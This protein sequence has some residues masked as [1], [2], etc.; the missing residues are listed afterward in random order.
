MSLARAN[1]YKLK[2]RDSKYLQKQKKSGDAYIEELEKELSEILGVFKTHI[3]TLSY[4]SS[5]VSGQ[6]LKV[7]EEIH[8][9]F[10]ESR[11]VFDKYNID[12]FQ[13]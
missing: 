3:Y 13:C 1:Y 6:K 11:E 5:F 9:T 10:A 12:I 2:Y 4:A 8:E 7:E